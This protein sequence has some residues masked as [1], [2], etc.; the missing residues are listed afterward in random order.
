MEKIINVTGMHC[1]SCEILL[2]DVLS[3]ISGVQKVVTDHK[4]GT[5]VVSASDD[6]V[7]PEIKRLIENEGYK[8]ID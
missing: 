3:E 2:D 8:V 6:S 4:K 7:L 1:K 5:V